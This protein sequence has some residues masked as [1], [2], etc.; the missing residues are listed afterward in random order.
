MVR[1]VS[2]AVRVA[3]QPRVVA[4]LILDADTG[5]ARGISVASTDQEACA[6]AMRKALTTPAGPLPPQAPAGVFCTD[7]HAATVVSE[8]APLLAG[9]AMPAVA[10]GQPV[11]EAEDIFDSFIG[12]LA[13]RRQPNEFPAPSDWRTLLAQ[14][15][16]YCQAQ[17]WMRMSDAD[18]LNI[19]VTIDGAAARYVAVVIGQQ[20]I[21]RGLV[22]YPDGA[23]RNGRPNWRPDQPVPLPA[24]TLLLWLDPADQIPPEFA[25]KAARYGWPNTTD[26]LP[27]CL[28]YGPDGPADIDRCSA[29]HLA[30]AIAAVRAQDQRRRNPGNGATKTTGELTLADNRRGTY[31][32]N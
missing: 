16:D 13:G 15:A 26:L 2:H 31:S 30:L 9:A 28:I 1:D 32:I 19:T 27:M 8:L 12:H 22:L 5:L 3:D 14:A 6:E 25:A 29:H 10:E 17:P 7:G 11:S 24:G 4:T 18:T 20:G 21:Q 23:P